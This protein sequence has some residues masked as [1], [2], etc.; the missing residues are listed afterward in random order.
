MTA[1]EPAERGTLNEYLTLIGADMAAGIL[2]KLCNL[3]PKL[4]PIF[5]ADQEL[6]GHL[7][8]RLRIVET[9]A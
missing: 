6:M 8:Q 3:N 2:Q 7:S 1:L 4:V 5:N 9:S